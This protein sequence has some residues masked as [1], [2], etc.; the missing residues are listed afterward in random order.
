V[1]RNLTIRTRLAVPALTS[2][3]RL[4]GPFLIDLPESQTTVELSVTDDE[5]GVTN[6]G[7]PVIIASRARDVPEEW[8]VVLEDITREKWPEGFVPGK[9]NDFLSDHYPTGLRSRCLSTLKDLRE[10]AARVVTLLR[11]R[12][13][14]ETWLGDHVA[15]LS[16]LGNE[17]ST[18]G[19]HWHRLR[20]GLYGSG[21]AIGGGLGLTLERA[22]TIEAMMRDGLAEP[23]GREMW[24]VA[25]SARD[26]R[27]A[28]VMAVSA[29]EVE[30]QR[31]IGD[32][33]PDAGW[34]AA[35]V[36]AP[37]I[38]KIIK[39]YVPSLP[40]VPED[41]LPPDALIETLKK[42]VTIRNE[43]VH[44]GRPT[45][46]SRRRGSREIKSETADA[47]RDAT[48]DVLWLFD[49]Y[50]GH[51]WAEGCLSPETRASFGLPERE[52]RE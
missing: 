47:I 48:S 27:V 40:D 49:L 38:E 45:A 16:H 41:R 33:V 32:L 4:A 36:I 1:T 31:L 9:P 51:S 29:V 25:Y 6:S 43:V 11:W 22:N 46:P 39:D 23:L 8:C 15:A 17:W 21:P 50:R 42:A 30:L 2:R 26:P 35:T 18:D 14:H 20:L 5:P 12:Y 3:S 7:T 10:V 13:T 19:E 34:L 37:P 44:V 24:H 28:V 52:E